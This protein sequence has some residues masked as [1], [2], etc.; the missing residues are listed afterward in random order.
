MKVSFE[1]SFFD[2]DGKLVTTNDIDVFA[3]SFG[4]YENIEEFKK[5]L[6]EVNSFIE[7]FKKINPLN[8]SKKELLNSPFIAENE[9]FIKSS[10]TVGKVL[11]KSS[12][13]QYNRIY[14]HI[15]LGGNLLAQWTGFK[16]FTL[17]PTSYMDKASCVQTDFDSNVIGLWQC[18]KIKIWKWIFYIPVRVQFLTVASVGNTTGHYWNAIDKFTND[19]VDAYSSLR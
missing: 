11:N 14:E 12:S 10:F 7:N 15:N 2:K 1:M 5:G 6:I 17:L 4:Q 8:L 3:K 16:I 13:A 18:R 9:Q 19:V